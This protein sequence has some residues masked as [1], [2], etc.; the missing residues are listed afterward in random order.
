MSSENIV[1]SGAIVLIILALVIGFIFSESDNPD[2]TPLPTPTANPSVD[3]ALFDPEGT[4][5]NVS[6]I[7]DSKYNVVCY[8]HRDKIDCVHVP[9]GRKE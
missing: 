5:Y 9:G 6:R 4:W 7:Y 2:P 1:I 8:V 3:H